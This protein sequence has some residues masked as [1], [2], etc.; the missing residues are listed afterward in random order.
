MRGIAAYLVMTYH[1]EAGRHRLL[2]SGQ[3]A[4]EIFFVLSGFVITRSLLREHDKMRL[5]LFYIRRA[6]RLV[7]ALVAFIALSLALTRAWTGTVP[8]NYLWMAGG[9]LLYCSNIVLMRLHGGVEVFGGL[10]SLSIEEQ[11]Y[12]LWPLAL[13]FLVRHPRRWVYGVLTA[14]AVGSVAVRVRN[15]SPGASEN[16]AAY[17]TDARSLGLMLGCLAAIATVSGVDWIRRVPAI[18]L[19]LAAL[20]ATGYLAASSLLVSRYVPRTFVTWW[21]GA[22]VASLVLVL[23]L[24]HE[25]PTL[26][27]RVFGNVLL[28]ALGKISYSLYLWHFFV[29]SVLQPR[30]F[31]KRTPT[32][33]TRYLAL[34]SLSLFVATLSYLLI[35]RPFVQLGR[36]I[37]AAPRWISSQGPSLARR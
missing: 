33:P 29:I 22:P 11:F 8:S 12:L 14:A 15:L 10:W 34:A 1:I 9:A 7:P 18:A 37:T 24:S 17:G 23:V 21:L 5:R 19:D 25:R 3:T 30:L 16:W 2:G 13:R 32:D 35:E 4:M 26:A 31:P 6:L 28:V 20:I 36:A 27:A